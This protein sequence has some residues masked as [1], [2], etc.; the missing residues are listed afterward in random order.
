MCIAGTS[1]HTRRSGI[2]PDLESRFIGVEQHVYNP[3]VPQVFKPQR[4]DMFIEK[5]NPPPLK[6]QRG[7]MCTS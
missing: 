3:T 6:P 1:H 4:G 5:R 2:L 7:D